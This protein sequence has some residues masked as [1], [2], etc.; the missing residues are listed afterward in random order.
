MSSIICSRC[1]EPL[2]DEIVAE[3]W[4]DRDFVEHGDHL[5]AWEPTGDNFAEARAVHAR[6]RPLPGAWPLRGYG[7][8]A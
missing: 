1:G 6:L 5:A 3:V 8:A 2:P 7:G 4:E